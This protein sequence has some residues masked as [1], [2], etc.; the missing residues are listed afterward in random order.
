MKESRGIRDKA[1][2]NKRS[3][4]TYTNAY[5]L[6][7]KNRRLLDK[8]LKKKGEKERENSYKDFV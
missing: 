7:T 4:K 1:K 3:E 8:R 2:Q 5:G 6:M